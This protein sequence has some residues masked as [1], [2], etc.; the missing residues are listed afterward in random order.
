MIPTLKGSHATLRC[1]P[2]RV[3]IHFSSR[4]GGGAR[5]SRFALPPAIVFIPFGDFLSARAL[6][7][8][9]ASALL[10]SDENVAAARRAV[11]GGDDDGGQRR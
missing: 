11:G 3:G 7:D 1:D 10:K 8:G 9:R 4:S 6:P 2:F 5:R